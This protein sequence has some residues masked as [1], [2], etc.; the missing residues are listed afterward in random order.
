[1]FTKTELAILARIVTNHCR[2]LQLSKLHARDD[3]MRARVTTALE[4]VQPLADKLAAHMPPRQY[5]KKGT[6]NVD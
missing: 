3:A 5:R 1:M 6:P 2:V 4:E